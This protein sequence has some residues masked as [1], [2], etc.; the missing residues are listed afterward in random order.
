MKRLMSVITTLAVL[1]AFAAA[2]PAR[3]STEG[4]AGEV[5]R[6]VNIERAASG[7]SPLAAGDS[8]LSGAAQ[9][10]AE[11]IPLRFEHLRPDGRGY[12]TVLDEYNVQYTRANEVLARGFTAPEEVVRSWMESDSHRAAIL[13]KDFTRASAGI[14]ESGGKLHWALLF[15]TPDSG[16]GIADIFVGVWNFIVG[17]WNIFAVV[18]NILT[19]LLGGG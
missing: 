14:F 3:A 16:G 6:L 17:I 4:F 12:D 13:D 1:A 7:L 19:R 8:A 9:K 2:V 18:G 5:L 10:R 11:E 15:I